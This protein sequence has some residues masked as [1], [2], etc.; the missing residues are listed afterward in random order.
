M[1]HELTT[2]KLFLNYGQENETVLC[3]MTILTPE[4][5]ELFNCFCTTCGIAFE[6][7]YYTNVCCCCFNKYIK[8]G[9][10]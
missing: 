7:E 8:S 10:K 5:P 4:P 9:D 1:K 6:S 2:G 3:E